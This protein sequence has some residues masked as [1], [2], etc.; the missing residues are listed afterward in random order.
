[1]EETLRALG[2]ILLNAIPT[3]VLIVFLFF[4]LRFAFIGPMERVMKARY[5][6]TEGARKLAEETVHRS[7]ARGREYEEAIRAARAEIYQAQDQ[8]HRQLQQEQEAQI[9]AARAESDEFI[10]RAKEELSRDVEQAKLALDRDS[11][12]LAGQIA[13]IVLN[14]SVA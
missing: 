3:F 12:M 9:A 6:A 1:M 13:E 7:E 2:G 8:L 4:F 14:R 5:D 11:E 10:K